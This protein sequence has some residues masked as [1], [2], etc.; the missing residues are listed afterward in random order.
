LEI[1]L[2]ALLS[3]GLFYW[4]KANPVAVLPFVAY[5]G[6]RSI[7][8]IRTLD[9]RYYVL[10]LVGLA[11]FVDDISQVAWGRDIQMVTEFM[12]KILFESYGLTG[13]EMISIGLVVWIL[14]VEQ[15]FEK[16][17]WLRCGLV[18]ITVVAFAYF[19]ASFVSGAV[20]LLK[21]GDWR[22]HFIQS[23]F[24]HLLPLWTLIGFMTLD[25]WRWAERLLKIATIVMILKSC[26]AILVYVIYPA[27]ARDPEYLV[28][29]YFSMFSVLAGV[30]IVGTILYQRGSLIW[31]AFLAAG[32]LPI[33]LAYILNERRTSYVGVAFALLL[34]LGFLPMSW[35]RQYWRRL[36]MGGIAFVLAVGASWFL[37]PPLDFVKATV[38]SFQTEQAQGRPTYR[39]LEN[40]NL[41]SATA[42]AP[43]L[44]LGTGREFEE[45]FIMPDISFVYD[46]YRMIPHNLFLGAWAYG[47][48][49]GIVSLS[50]IFT[51]MLATAGRLFR[52]QASPGA[53]LFAIVSLFYLVQYIVYTYGDLGLQIP[54]NQMFSG[55]FFGGCY[56][57]LHEPELLASARSLGGGVSHES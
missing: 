7:P 17:K 9:Y 12:G 16:L 44:G 32:L 8:L 11:L 40:A 27:G 22:V 26:Q 35:Y 57:L 24:L 25:H 47:G 38:Q 15:D 39:Q 6:Y 30:Y 28:D 18:G 43:I 56:R 21:G 36:F 20:G 34:F 55:L 51:L 50:V 53:R 10:M 3:G 13:L 54:R 2:F 33:G 19:L 31:R 1:Q 41:L 37:P 48:L 46:R 23:R 14:L 42:S 45:V 52:G 5:C 29:H 49:L 4:L